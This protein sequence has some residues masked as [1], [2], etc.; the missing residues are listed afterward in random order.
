MEKGPGR[1]ALC[2]PQ[3]LTQ[4]QGPGTWRLEDSQYLQTLKICISGEQ[5]KDVY[6]IPKLSQN[7]A[8]NVFQF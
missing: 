1:E 4:A 2:P 3:V 5:G 6:H 8:Y 7:N